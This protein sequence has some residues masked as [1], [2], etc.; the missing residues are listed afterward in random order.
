MTVLI[1]RTAHC[2]CGHPIFFRN[3]LCL[4]CGRALGFDPD[5]ATIF[6]H[7]SVP[8]LTQLMLPFLSL[9]SVAEL[10]RNPLH[11]GALNLTGVIEVAVEVA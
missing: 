8:A 4:H 10:Q 6:T 1:Q 9:V 3:H 5:Q 11:R 7:A 2:Q